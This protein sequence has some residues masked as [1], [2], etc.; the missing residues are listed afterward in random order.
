MGKRRLKVM[1]YLKN[2]FYSKRESIAIKLLTILFCF[3]LCSCQKSPNIIFYT[4]VSSDLYDKDELS[5]SNEDYQDALNRCQKKLDEVPADSLAAAYVYKM[6]G[7]IYAGYLEDADAAAYYINKAI[8]ID[9]RENNEIGLALD[10]NQ[11]SKIYICTGGDIQEGLQFLEKAEQIYEQHGMLDTFEMAGT[12]INKGRLY[13][14]EG[15]YE[16]AINYMIEAQKIYIEGQDEDIQL[17]IEIGQIY[18]EMKDYEKAKEQYV[19]AQKICESEEDIY[20]LAEVKN[21]IAWLYFEQEDY[22]TAIYY[23]EQALEFYKKNGFVKK[24]AFTCNNMASAVYR[25]ALGVDK[26]I[27]LSIDACRAI[28][29]VIPETIPSSKS[30][31]N[32][33]H[34]LK[35]YYMEWSKDESEEGFKAWYQKVVL[36]GKDWKE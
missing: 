21:Q 18:L 6:M 29:K 15:N 4:D 20:Y 25:F 34:N 13:N 33:K 23:Y 28:E 22:K 14:L 36:E 1:Q 16:K 32:Y 19:K 35:Y 30:K 9:E 17:Y 31:K 27:P 26:A 3:I 10:Y 5:V 12:L 8:Q 7:G 2:K 11:M 24:E